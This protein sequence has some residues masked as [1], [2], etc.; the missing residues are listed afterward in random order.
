[1]ISVFITADE[2]ELKITEYYETLTDEKFGEFCAKI[3]GKTIVY[4]GVDTNDQAI[5]EIE[6]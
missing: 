4:R 2:L 3:L 1:M 6:S 5:Y